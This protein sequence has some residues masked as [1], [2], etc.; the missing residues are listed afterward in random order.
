TVWPHRLCLDI[1]VTTLNDLQNLLGMIN[2]V[3]PY[4]G[5]ATQQLKYLFDLL[6]EDPD[7]TSP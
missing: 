7:L 2:W 6:K 1:E 3:Q 5:I 4:L